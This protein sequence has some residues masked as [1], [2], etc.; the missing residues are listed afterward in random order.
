MTSVDIG[1][2]HS[3]TPGY[4]NLDPVHGT[5]AL[6]TRRAEDGPLP[7]G[8]Q[9]VEAIRASHVLEHIAGPDIIPVMNEFHRVLVP[10]GEL[11]VIVPQFPSWQAMADPTHI[12]FWVPERFAYFT[13]VAVA[14]AEYSIRY[15]I[16]LELAYNDDASMTWR[17]T[18]R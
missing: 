17:G 9:S 15:W 5:N 4:D 2:G 7:Y 11:T 1:G 13:G 14:Q 6:L 10:G 18:P 8:N 3:P 16:E 12:S